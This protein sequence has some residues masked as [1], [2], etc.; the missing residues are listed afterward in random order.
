[1]E[2]IQTLET[3]SDDREANMWIFARAALDLLAEAI[4]NASA[5]VPPD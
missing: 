2:R 4:D 1:M 3:G 5:I